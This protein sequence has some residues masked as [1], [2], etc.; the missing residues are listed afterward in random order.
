MKGL[1]QTPEHLVKYDEVIKDQLAN[2]VA[3][4]ECE[5][6][7]ANKVSYLISH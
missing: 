6:E 3:E 5:L 1:R 2:D 7:Q 4:E